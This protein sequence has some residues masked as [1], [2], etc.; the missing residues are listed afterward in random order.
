MAA[1]I[2]P[3]AHGFLPGREAAQSWLQIQAAAE[4]ALSGDAALHGLATDLKRAFNNI[5][6]KPL[7]EVAEFLGFPEDL[8]L[9]WRSFLSAFRRR[10]RIGTALSDPV[11]S[12]CGFTE[13]DPL[14][15]VAMVLLDWMLHVFQAALH[16][17]VRLF[18]F[19]DNLS[20]VSKTAEPLVMAC[21]GLT[22]FL[23]LLGL[24]I[25][26]DKSYA[27]GTTQESRRQVAPLGFSVVDVARELGGTLNFGL[28]PRVL[29]FFARSRDLGPKWLRLKRSP[30]PLAQKLVALPMAFWSCAL[31]GAEGSLFAESHIHALRIRALKELGLQRAGLNATLR[32]SLAQPPTADPGYY[33]LKH[34]VQN[35]RRILYKSPDMLV[36]W[37]IF[38]QHF[39][40]R[41]L[42][43]P[44]SKLLALFGPLGWIVLEPPWIQ[45]HDGVQ[46]DLL[47]IDQ[48]TLDVILFE[49]WLQGLAKKVAHRKN[50]SDLRGLDPYLTILDHHKLVPKDYARVMAIQ[51]GSFLDVHHH[52]K[53]DKTKD[54]ICPKCGVEDSLEHWFTCDRYL[55]L[56]T[57]D[58][59]I[60]SLPVR[61]P[62]SILH[63]L[64]IPRSPWTS[65]L[66]HH[67]HQLS[68]R[69]DCFLSEP[70]EG[71]QHIFTDG[72]CFAGSTPMLCQA[73][74]AAINA[75]TGAPIGA[76]QLSGMRQS[77]GRAEITAVL[78]AIKWA[79][80]FESAVCIWCDS[81]HVVQKVQD[82]LHGLTVEIL[83]NWENHDLWEQVL[84]EI[85]NGAAVSIRIIWIPSHLDFQKCE[86]SLEEWISL[87]NAQADQLATETNRQRSD[88]FLYIQHQEQSYFDEWS[89]TARQ[90][91]DYL[92]AVAELRTGVP[93]EHPERLQVPFP[94]DWRE[95]LGSDSWSQLFPVNW[96]MRL[97]ATHLTFPCRFYETILG[98]V[99]DGEHDS[100]DWKVVSLVELTLWLAQ[101]QHLHFPFW[102]SSSRD[103]ELQDITLRFV[104]PTLST[105]IGLVRKA[106][107]ELLALFQIS[108][109][110]R[111]G[112]LCPAAAIAIDGLP[113]CIPD[114]LHARMLQLVKNFSGG[115]LIR[116]AADLAKPIQLV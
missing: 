10:F 63:H 11:T 83:P 100:A 85:Q 79:N 105:L 96:Q 59:Q 42:S 98:H 70:S 15:V 43:G 2:H 52:A 95:E 44:F 112:L 51:S 116:K 64:L 14:S 78:A 48:G 5:R 87:W 25:D 54:P 91:R 110:Y 37:R 73:A 20:I 34:V 9:P 61:V 109:L 68:D 33:Q 32:L 19:V 35:F 101:D 18:S 94:A 71:L 104:R 39:E 72:S 115:R 65:S 86:S 27:W 8:L 106:V 53:Y 28:S 23:Q 38:M 80:Y 57:E 12:N 7:F 103:W 111:Q 29:D 46:F 67:F 90:V 75:R 47:T 58:P 49:A 81:Q 107:E 24:S 84:E 26:P 45:D 60:F 88:R 50:M 16:P 99:L 97:R 41:L 30:A 66:K 102:S 74:W 93:N 40:G 17:Q 36:Q 69:V 1:F 31:H 22:S 4:L 3:D 55:D 113:L 92:L 56:R 89:P 77:I 108:H 114:E 62:D 6:R 21:F 13:G 82:I 76:G